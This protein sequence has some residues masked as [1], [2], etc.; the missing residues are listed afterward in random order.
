MNQRRVVDVAVTSVLAILIAVLAWQIVDR[1]WLRSAPLV[2]NPRPA[3]APRIGSLLPLGTRTLD[4]RESR[5][6]VV[7]VLGTAC[8]ITGASAGLYQEL[9]HRVPESPSWSLLVIADTRDAEIDTWLESRQVVPDRVIRTNLREAGL[10]GTPMLY[11]AEPDGRITDMAIGQLTGDQERRLWNR[12]DRLPGSAALESVSARYLEIADAENLVRTSGAQ[13]VDLRDRETTRASSSS[14]INI[15]I[16]EL[17]A[18]ARVR[19]RP[20]LPIILECSNFDVA[21]CNLAAQILA[22]FGFS[23]VWLV[24]P[25]IVSEAH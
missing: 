3:E 8:A 18:T 25:A 1:L 12:L 11:L 24:P 17:F 13:M 10:W 2:G 4:A 6:L 15:P 5:P 20:S 21:Q 7:L 19:L 23:E 14:N 22:S 16:D 9:S